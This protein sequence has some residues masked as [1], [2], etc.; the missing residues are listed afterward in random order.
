MKRIL[1]ACLAF[2]LSLSVTAVAVVPATSAPLRL[3]TPATAEVP[4][5]VV[6]AGYRHRRY[7]RHHHHRPHARYHHRRNHA[8]PIVGG[9]VA[10]AV[11][12]GIIATQP[13]YRYRSV[14]SAHIA[15]CHSRYRSYDSRSNTFQP[16]NGPRRICRSPY[17]Y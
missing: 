6:Q 16:Y 12:G 7:H 13:A 2:A 1:S 11:I 10:G 9:L 15:W 5:D 8:G 3:S 17:A 14:P 4:N